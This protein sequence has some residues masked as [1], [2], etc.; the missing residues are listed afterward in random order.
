M[1]I[2]THLTAFLREKRTRLTRWILAQRI[3]ARHPTLRVDP[4]AIWDYGYHD[5]DAIE[6]GQDVSVGAFAEVVVYRKSPHSAIP[7]RLVLGNRSVL[8]TGVNI[9]AAGGTISLG[10]GSVLS[11]HTVA[12]AANH[13]TTGEQQYLHSKW[14]ELRTG[15]IVGNNVW[16]GANCV[17]LPGTTIGDNSVIAAG[18][19]VRGAIPAGEVWGGVPAR[20]LREV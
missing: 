9:R 20:K 14:D 12:V 19:V 15:V 1:S 7:G 10:A 8:A 17:L 5:I 3:A 11:Q 18:A 4:T 6:V 16:V 2:T 13:D